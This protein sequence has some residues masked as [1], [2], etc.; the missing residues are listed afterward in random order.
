M[1]L[2]DIR[3]SALL[4]DLLETSAAHYHRCVAKIQTMFCEAFFQAL[5][6]RQAQNI[7]FQPDEIALARLTLR[8]RQNELI[9]AEKARWE[10][11][12]LA[13]RAYIESLTRDEERCAA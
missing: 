7:S 11:R 8:L 13:I 9:A 10:E 2:I 1:T 5:A 3:E 4:D 12:N 6:E